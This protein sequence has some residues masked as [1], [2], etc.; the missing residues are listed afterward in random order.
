MLNIFGYTYIYFVCHFYYDNPI[1]NI[2]LVFVILCPKSA[3]KVFQKNITIMGQMK[4][5]DIETSQG[6]TQCIE[7][8]VLFF[9][10]FISYNSFIIFVFQLHFTVKTCC[11]QILAPVRPFVLCVLIRTQYLY[12]FIFCTLFIPYPETHVILG[13]LLMV[14]QTVRSD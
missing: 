12:V 9:S 11:S 4:G 8:I 6:T 13:C 14:H 3:W 5:K 7:H 1:G 2:V 10:R